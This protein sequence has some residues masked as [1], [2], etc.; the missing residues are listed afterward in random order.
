LRRILPPPSRTFAALVF[1]LATLAGSAVR[2]GIL[3]GLPLFNDT[4]T[5]LI[6][7][8]YLA[9][10]RLGGPVLEDSAFWNMQFM[11]NTGA[12][13]VSQYPPGHVVALA[14]GFL[15]GAPWL[16]G[17][18]MAGLAAVFTYLTCRGLLPADQITAR[19]SALLVA[20]SPFQAGL[21]GAYMSHVT[22][23]ALVMM[24]AWTAVRTRP[25]ESPGWP[26]AVGVALGALGTVRPYSAVVLGG[27]VTAAV[28]TFVREEIDGV[29]GRVTITDGEDE[30][31]FRWER[32]VDGG[33]WEITAD[34]AMQRGK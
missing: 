34:G 33:P 16:V 7:A 25:R 24:V 32:S 4:M 18:A 1:V 14:A 9:A 22:A 31:S 11:L 19:L 13:W 29:V 17:P 6:H 23:A 3:D 20:L 27:G 5:Q 26:L 28:W 10:G 2:L 8:R 21:A 15:V 30:K 12:G